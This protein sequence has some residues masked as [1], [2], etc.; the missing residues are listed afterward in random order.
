MPAASPISVLL[1]RVIMRLRSPRTGTEVITP[2]SSDRL[3]IS[4]GSQTVKRLVCPKTPPTLEAVRILFQLPDDMKKEGL[5]VAAAFRHEGFEIEDG[6]RWQLLDFETKGERSLRPTRGAFNPNRSGAR[7]RTAQFGGIGGIGEA[8]E[9]NQF[10]MGA[11]TRRLICGQEPSSS[12][13]V[14][15]KHTLYFWAKS[16][17]PFGVAADILDVDLAR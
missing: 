15:K 6:V 1:H 16:N 17:D 7:I 3:V 8:G 10:P 5:V 13:E 14:L 12:F 9:M 2:L 4:P 11:A